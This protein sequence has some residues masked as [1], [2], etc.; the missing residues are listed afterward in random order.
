MYRSCRRFPSIFPFVVIFTYAPKACLTSFV[1][2]S[3]DPG[4]DLPCLMTQQ[5]NYRVTCP[6]ACPTICQSNLTDVIV[7]AKYDKMTRLCEC[8]EAVGYCNW[9]IPTTNTP[10]IFFLPGQIRFRLFAFKIGG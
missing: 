10:Y 4:I 5:M 2:L 6:Q 1:T 7:V 9:E 8:L 3:T